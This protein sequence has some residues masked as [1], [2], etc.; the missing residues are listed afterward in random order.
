VTE[1]TKQKIA[2]LIAMGFTIRE[3]A[4]EC[5]ITENTIYNGLKGTAT[6][7]RTE[8]KIHECFKK[9]VGIRKSQINKAM[10]LM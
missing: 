1:Q 6:S 4:P 8:Q 9:F 2:A 5:G 10:E 7:G 3:I